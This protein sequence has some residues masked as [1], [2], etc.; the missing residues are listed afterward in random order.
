MLNKINFEYYEVDLLIL[1]DDNFYLS[2]L[3]TN[4]NIKHSPVEV[5]MLFSPLRK[6]AWISIKQKQW[7][8]IK[9]KIEIAFRSKIYKLLNQHQKLYELWNIQNKL[10]PTIDGVYDVAVGYLQ[11]VSIYFVVDKVKARK[12]IGW[13]HNDYRLSNMNNTYDEKFFNTLDAIYSVSLASKESFLSVFPQLSNKIKTMYNIVTEDVIRQR[14]EEEVVF[15]TTYE[16]V[17]I[18]T[19]GRLH[20]QKGYDIVVKVC[21]KLCKDNV[22]FKWYVIGKGPLQKEILKKAVQLGVSHRLILLGEKE[23]PYPYVKACD[24]YVQPSIAEGFGIAVQEAKILNRPIIV[25]DCPAMKEQIQH[26][27]NGLVVRK[28]AESVYEALKL[29]IENP[30]MRKQFTDTLSHSQYS[31]EREMQTLYQALGDSDTFS[32]QEGKLVT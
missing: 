16:G 8:F 28:N 20:P 29:L 31:S 23:N 25:T 3:T 1:S 18:V 4:V 32:K 12:K 5:K 21:E 15:D 7:K 6:A 22:E 19:V 13:I 26:L 9:A 24:V 11:G 2:Q 27:H 17:V 14:S 10:I 30:T